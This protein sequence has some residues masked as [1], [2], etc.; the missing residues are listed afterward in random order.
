MYFLL[1][2]CH[3]FVIGF[4]GTNYLQKRLKQGKISYILK[5]EKRV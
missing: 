1:N 3:F 4:C 5:W 2:K